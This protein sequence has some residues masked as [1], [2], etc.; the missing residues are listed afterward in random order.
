MI[1]PLHKY[2]HLSVSNTYVVN[3]LQGKLGCEEFVN[4]FNFMASKDTSMDPAFI[5]S[6]TASLQEVL[7]PWS[8]GSHVTYLISCMPAPA[9][10][11]MMYAVFALFERILIGHARPLRT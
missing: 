2:M 7:S 11:D 6:I 4:L 10:L 5:D 1:S 9:S 8:L 3:T